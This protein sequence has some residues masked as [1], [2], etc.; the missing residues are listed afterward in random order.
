[1][2]CDC[3]ETTKQQLRKMLILLYKNQP[4]KSDVHSET[5]KETRSKLSYEEM[6]RLKR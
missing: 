2:G 5:Y 1:M 6:Q 4:G 3:T